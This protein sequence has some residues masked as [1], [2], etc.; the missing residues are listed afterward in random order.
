MKALLLF[1][2]FAAFFVSLTSSFYV[3]NDVVKL[4]GR[5]VVR[6]QRSV[7]NKKTKAAKKQKKQKKPTKKP[8]TKPTKK[9]VNGN[10][11]RRSVVTYTVKPITPKTTPHGRISKD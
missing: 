4:D 10:T 6:A 3:D 7:N 5:Q 1:C 2:L 11:T 8:T 9:P